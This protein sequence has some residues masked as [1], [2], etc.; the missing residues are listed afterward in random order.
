M[1]MAVN[2][3]IES[4]SDKLNNPIKKK[5]IIY[6]FCD[7]C[8][9]FVAKAFQY[10]KD[11]SWRYISEVVEEKYNDL[12][13]EIHEFLYPLFVKNAELLTSISLDEFIE[14][15]NVKCTELVQDGHW[16]DEI[17]SHMKEV[18]GNMENKVNSMVVPPFEWKFD[19]ESK[20]SVMKEL[21]DNKK[22]YL[23]DNL[24]SSVC[25]SVLHSFNESAN[26]ILKEANETMWINLRNLMSAKINEARN[27]IQ[28][29]L[30]TNIPNEKAKTDISKKF[31]DAAIKLVKESAKY[32]LLKMKSAFDK[33]FKYENNRPRIWTKDDDV[34]QIFDESKSAGEAVLR[35]FTICKLWDP[36][37]P[38]AQQN[39]A[40]NQILID[41]DTSEKVLEGYNRIIAHTYEEAKGL[42]KAQM[43]QDQIPSFAWFILL[44]LG[45]D[46]ILKLLANP[47]IF[48]FALF[49]GGSYFMLKQLGLLDIVLEAIKERFYNITSIFSDDEADGNEDEDEGEDDSN[50]V[51][52]NENDSEI[53]ENT[54]DDKETN[55]LKQEEGLLDLSKPLDSLVIPELPPEMSNETSEIIEESST[56]DIDSI[57]PPLPS[58]EMDIDVPDPIESL[59]TVVLKKKKKRK[60]NNPP[61]LTLKPNR[62]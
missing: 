24:H 53:V 45:G 6:D 58:E 51:Q 59:D 9:P 5:E 8:E 60:S 17:N 36:N 34:N 23:I 18:V 28:S 48:T 31:E 12:K 30:D 49:F 62:H 32:I 42:I 21:I 14:Y 10:Y 26:E 55:T 19:F 57:M 7:I 15:V 13:T 16:F 46:K 1:K 11:N 27:T 29:I 35:L 25:S 56:I 20:E 2:E 61:A 41:K 22:A 52:N 50:L 40:L 47:L 4:L 54:D 43:T 33:H 44:I 38:Q 3:L 37:K 39:P